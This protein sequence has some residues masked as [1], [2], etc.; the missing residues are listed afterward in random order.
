MSF[1]LISLTLSYEGTHFQGWQDNGHNRSVEGELKKALARIFGYFPKVEGA[2]RTDAGVHATNQ[3]IHF[4]SKS[5]RSNGSWVRGTNTYLP[6]DIAIKNIFR[7]KDS[8]HA[9][10]DAKLRSYIYLIK[11]LQLY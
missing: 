11:F 9:R 1:Y 8:L 7:V 3:I 6:D 4:D 5:R 10:F 2:S